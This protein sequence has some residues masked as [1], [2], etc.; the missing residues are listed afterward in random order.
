MKT[1]IVLALLALIA[2]QAYYFILKYRTETGSKWVRFWAAF[3]YAGS[4]LW[5]HI[6]AMTASLFGVVSY[7]LDAFNLPEVKAWLTQKFDAETV[8]AI[9]AAVAVTTIVVRLRGYDV[10]QA[11]ADTLAEDRASRI[12]N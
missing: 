10:S 5:Q 9:F 11:R 6:V 1:I 7:A 3:Q 12:G 8:A 4:I 2:V